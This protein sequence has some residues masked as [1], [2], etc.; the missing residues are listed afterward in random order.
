MSDDRSFSLQPGT[1]YTVG[2]QPGCDVLVQDQHVSA[3]HC[4]IWAKEETSG[5]KPAESSDH[6]THDC[7]VQGRG[8]IHG[9]N[10][11]HGGSDTHGDNAAHGGS[12]TH[13]DNAA[14]GDSDTHGYSN[15]V[16]YVVDLSRNGTWLK[17]KDASSSSSS[18]AA[19]RRIAKKESIPLRYGDTVYLKSPL[20]FPAAA[21]CPL[22][23]QRCEERVCVAASTSDVSNGIIQF[24]RQSDG[25]EQVDNTGKGTEEVCGDCSPSPKRARCNGDNE[26]TTVPAADKWTTEQSQFECCPVCMQLVPISDFLEHARNCASDEGGRNATGGCGGDTYIRVH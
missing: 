5:E 10:A 8:D 23:V 2:R 19:A 12:D 13:G 1:R 7:H 24:V 9:D 16:A 25:G 3:L 18:A 15:D 21:S 26:T 17:R 14:H 4:Y 11:A 22:E 20:S 6:T